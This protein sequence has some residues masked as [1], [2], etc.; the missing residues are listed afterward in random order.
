MSEMISRSKLELLTVRQI[1]TFCREHPWVDF[2]HS[3]GTM[4]YL[5]TAIKPFKQPRR[6]VFS[7]EV[8][9]TFVRFDL[10]QA[11]WWLRHKRFGPEI[12]RRFR[13]ALDCTNPMTE[14]HPQKP[15]FLSWTKADSDLGVEKDRTVWLITGHFLMLWQELF[16]QYE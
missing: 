2:H 10:Y 13:F 15:T 4:L 3:P 9:G 7:F 6:P 12:T 11:G 8:G 16:D 5:F 1:A 14:L